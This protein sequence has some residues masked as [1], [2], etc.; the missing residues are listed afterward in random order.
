[1]RWFIE[2]DIKGCFDNINHQVLV[3]IINTKIKDA[4]LIKQI[5]KLL[6][7][8]Y[9]EAW[10]YFNTYSGTPQGRIMSP[11]FANIYMNELDKFV[12]QLAVDFDKPRTQCLTPEYDVLQKNQ[13]Y[14][15]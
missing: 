4:R 5:H 1:M 13:A 8:G 11:I 14:Q 6:K 9:L 15:L 10:Q 2:G 12:E 3:S 7:A